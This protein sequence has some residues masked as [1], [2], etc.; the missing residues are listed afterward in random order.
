MSGCHDNARGGVDQLEARISYS[1][2]LCRNKCT[3]FYGFPLFGTGK[4][5]VHGKFG[6]PI[7]AELRGSDIQGC[8]KGNVEE[9]NGIW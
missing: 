4:T 5:F 1:G 2:K 6:N 3:L 8:F 9:L 7:L